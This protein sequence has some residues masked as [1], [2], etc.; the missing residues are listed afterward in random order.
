MRGRA[1]AAAPSL[2]RLSSRRRLEP[3]PVTRTGPL[4]APLL[5]GAAVETGPDQA[6]ALLVLIAEEVVVDRSRE[7]RVVA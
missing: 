7:G 5:A 1:V 3:R 2:G 4:R 6:I